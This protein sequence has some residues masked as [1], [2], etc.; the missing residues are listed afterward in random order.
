MAAAVA[1]FR[2]RTAATDKLTRDGALTL[3]LEPTEDILAEASAWSAAGARTPA[4]ARPQPARAGGL[5]GRDGIAG[6]RVGQG[7]A[8]GR[9]P[10]G[11]ERRLGA[12]LRVRHGHQPRHDLAAGSRRRPGRSSPS[13]RSPTAS[14][15]ASAGRCDASATAGASSPRHECHASHAESRL[16]VVDI[17]RMYADGAAHSDAH[18]LRLPDR[19]VARRGRHPA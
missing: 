10:A 3:D 2:P 13:W 17:A 15:I 6:A 1:D 7:R 8:Q 4:R 9:R 18:G 11:R 12:G 5:R 19:A 14:S 16:T